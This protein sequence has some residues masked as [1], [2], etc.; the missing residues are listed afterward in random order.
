MQFPILLVFLDRLGILNV[1]QLRSLRRYVL[2]GVV[3]FAVVVTP[4]GDPVSPL[5]LAGTMYAL[6]EFT[7]FLLTRRAKR[8]PGDA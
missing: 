4:G 8:S 3:V 5:V 2:V 7:I 6:Y 1:D